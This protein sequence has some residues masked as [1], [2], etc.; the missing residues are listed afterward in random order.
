MSKKI[1]TGKVISTKMQET[2][3]ILVERTKCHPKYKKQ[4]K[5]SK[6][7]LAHNSKNNYKINQIVNIKET[8][9]FSKNKFFI[10][11]GIAKD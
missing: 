1:L 2:A 5:I 4:Y 10:I 6:K 11:I 3:V 7:Y 8:K 9:P